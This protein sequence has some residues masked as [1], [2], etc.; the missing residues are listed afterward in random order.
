M[1]IS[2]TGASGFIG[3]KLVLACLASGYE[4]RILSR[5][6]SFDIAGVILFHADLLDEKVK[7]NQFVKGADIV[8]NCA[9]DNT[10]TNVNNGCWG[11]TIGAINLAMTQASKELGLID[12]MLLT[13]GN[14][15]YIEVLLD[16]NTIIEDNLILHGLQ[17]YNLD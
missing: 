9:G 4:V 12:E 15:R 16:D 2:I 5:K 17:R 8:I 7:F 14:A 1:V 6:N 3:R 13:G 10:N 11:A